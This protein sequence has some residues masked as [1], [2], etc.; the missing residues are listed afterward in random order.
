MS[1]LVVIDE[2]RH[3]LKL[4]ALGVLEEVPRGLEAFKGSSEASRLGLLDPSRIQSGLLVQNRSK[5]G[6]QGDPISEICDFGNPDLRSILAKKCAG[7][8]LLFAGQNRSQVGDFPKS[9]QVSWYTHFRVK[10]IF[11]RFW[12][13]NGGVFLAP[14]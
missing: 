7:R 4:Q 11:R 10:S 3:G 13:K 1:Q 14:F 8:G 12:L 9:V 5:V 6:P 2:L